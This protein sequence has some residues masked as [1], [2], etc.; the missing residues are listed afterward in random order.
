MKKI[1]S[2]IL[3]TAVLIGGGIFLNQKA[4]A[5]PAP[6]IDFNGEIITFPYT[7]DNT[8]ENLIIRTDKQTY[9][10]WDSAVVYVMVEN[11]SGENQETKIKFIDP[12]Q[13]EFLFEIGRLEKDVE[14]QV[15][16]D[17]F[18]TV[19]YD[20]S[21]T[22]TSTGET[23][24]QTCEKQE[25]TGSHFETKYRDEWQPLEDIDNEA[26]FVLPKNKIAYFKTRIQFP[27]N[28]KDEF[29]IE[30]TGD[31]NGYGHL[32]PWYNSNWDYRREI[33][34]DP[35]K[36][37][38]TLTDFPV[39]VAFSSSTF[40]FSNAK[41]NGEDIRFTSSDG[42]TLIDFEQ[43]R[44]ASTTDGAVYWVEVP[45]VSS[46]TA[47][48]TTFYMYY[49]NAAASDGQNATGTW[50]NNFKAVW[51]S[52][53]SAGSLMD[54]TSNDEDGTFH[55]SLPDIGRGGKVG[56]G[57]DF[58]GTNDYIS[59]PGGISAM[60]SAFTIS[61]WAKH[62][63]LDNTR[64]EIMDLRD[65]NGIAIFENATDNKLKM[66]VYNGSGWENFTYGTYTTDIWYHWTFVWDGT[67]VDLFKDGTEVSSDNSIS[68]NAAAGGNCFIG[69][70]TGTRYYFDGLLDE[71]QISNT[72]RTSAWIKATY[73]SGNDSLL[74]FGEEE[75]E[76]P[77]AGK[78]YIKINQGNIKIDKG[79]LIIN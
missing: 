49:G 69:A 32:D 63:T 36:V 51:H 2:T 6:S 76:A 17:D 24:E 4:V 43:E 23:I 39:M 28:T 3:I 46:S 13:S 40:T 77:P 11:I 27:H 7:D 35:S 33:S 75:E 55:D 67:S 56:D 70:E 71:I 26:E 15:E 22:S 61:F 68:A 78:G 58:D 44:W 37:D 42:E 5:S 18:T 21:Y 62:D 8:G 29:F 54:S 66:A 38:D 53:E 10:G 48:T 25:K 73:N 19:Y 50:D 31:K 60:G 41:D 20:C 72:N 45:S 30:I 1:I 16:V 64:E 34:I 14:Y 74:S 47:A 59:I 12:K 57:Q 9:G 79:R 52:K 65:N